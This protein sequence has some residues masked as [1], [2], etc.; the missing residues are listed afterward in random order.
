[1]ASHKDVRL[2]ALSKCPNNPDYPQTMPLSHPQPLLAPKA[3]DPYGIPETQA[4]I[5]AWGTPGS[6]G[7]LSLTPE[8]SQQ[9]CDPHLPG[10]GFKQRVSEWLG[11]GSQAGEWGG[12]EQGLGLV[13]SGHIRQSPDYAPEEPWGWSG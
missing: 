7:L 2:M 5:L 8:V 11:V 10:A 4:Q 3:L 1:M 13:S 6:T 12:S 9:T